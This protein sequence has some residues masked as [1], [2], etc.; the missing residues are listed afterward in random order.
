MISLSNYW[1]IFLTLSITL[2]IKEFEASILPN[3]TPRK[4]SPLE[5]FDLSGSIEVFSSMNVLPSI[6]RVPGHNANDNNVL[7][8][9]PA[10]RK[11]TRSRVTEALDMIPLIF[12]AGTRLSGSRSQPTI[13]EQVQDGNISIA[14]SSCSKK[15][16]GLIELLPPMR[17]SNISAIDQLNI[18]VEHLI[19]FMQACS[20]ES[21]QE[22]NL[23]MD[24]NRNILDI[25]A[26]FPTANLTKDTVLSALDR[27]HSKIRAL[28][29]RA[30]FDEVAAWAIGIFE[31]TYRSEYWIL[32][33]HLIVNN[34]QYSSYQQAVKNASLLSATQ[35]QNIIKRLAQYLLEVR[36]DG[37]Y[38][39]YGKFNIHFLE[40]VRNRP[41]FT[42]QD[43]NISMT[44]T[45]Q[46][47]L[48]SVNIV[49]VISDSVFST[50]RTTFIIRDYVDY[51]T[52]LDL[53]PYLLVEQIDIILALNKARFDD[54]SEESKAVFLNL[55][56]E[57][58]GSLPKI[59]DAF[60]VIAGK[61]I[62][63]LIINGDFNYLL[64]LLLR[65][66]RP[67][68]TVNE[69]GLLLNLADSLNDKTPLGTLLTLLGSVT[70]SFAAW[71]CS[72]VVSQRSLRLH[73]YIETILS[74]QQQQL[75]FKIGKETNPFCTSII[76]MQNT[77]TIAW[78]MPTSFS[79]SSFE[80]LSAADM[81]LI[82]LL[83]IQ[84]VFYRDYRKSSVIVNYLRLGSDKPT[85]QQF[86]TIINQL[87]IDQC[88]RSNYQYP[89]VE[90]KAIFD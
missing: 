24:M 41:N 59:K 33:D 63:G 76:S 40:L 66:L 13:C 52:Q 61:E 88:Y 8:A 60:P 62:Y 65:N 89:I 71:T 73:F 49:H 64:T 43:L 14:P 6:S 34:I 75:E 32:L 10:R 3:L 4:R 25:L 83:F 46:L 58:I 38:V 55:V 26:Q 36:K 90:V 87:L 77:T 56:S 23:S 12:G 42:P 35:M 70:V 30:I 28:L 51:C 2:F 16:S 85:Y 11:S 20:S 5:S 27:I 79:K 81:L 17:S 47:I 39:S 80:S 57:S 37:E 15:S 45:S 44:P 82:P 21:Q 74:I 78:I 19:Q 68:F 22:S 54:L 84:K 48:K 9:Q 1:L 31:R 18:A 86:P 69:F 7:P 72:D 67:V 53:S 50:R 29:H